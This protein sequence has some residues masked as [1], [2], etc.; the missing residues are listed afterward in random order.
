METEVRN[1]LV[2]R[3]M[4]V[5]MIAVLAAG[6]ASCGKEGNRKDG[7]ADELHAEGGA[8]E[9]PILDGLD[10]D[11]NNQRRLFFASTA[12]DAPGLYAVNPRF[13]E[14]GAELVDDQI[15]PGAF[16]YYSVH[17]G[18]VNESTKALDG[19]Y[20]HQL[21]YSVK[22]P[23]EDAGPGITGYLHGQLRRV[24]TDSEQ[25]SVLP[26]QVG[27][28]DLGGRVFVET[29]RKMF[30]DFQEPLRTSF[31][32]KGPG[33]DS[34]ARVRLADAASVEPTI[35]GKNIGLVT[36]VAKPDAEPGTDWLVVHEKDEGKL[37][38]V[39]D[40][41]A[42]VAPVRFK[43]SGEEVKGVSNAEKLHELVSGE[44]M[45][46][47]S[48]EERALG[49]VW[50]YETDDS[51]G[52][53]GTIRALLNADGEKLVINLT[54]FTNDLGPPPEELTA[55]HQGAFFFASSHGG[56]GWSKLYRLDA[57]GWSR[58][59]HSAPAGSAKKDGQA[60]YFYSE[61]APFLLDAGSDGLL[62]SLGARLER[63]RANDADVNKWTRE[64]LTDQH[65]EDPYQSKL[66]K[67]HDTTVYAV[68]DG[69]VFYNAQHYYNRKYIHVAVALNVRDKQRVVLKN[70]TWI[71]AST[72][73][74]GTVNNRR[75]E[76]ELSEVFAL[77]NGREVAAVSAAD[78][79][80]G[81]VILGQLPASTKNVTMY[82]LGPG[83]HRLLRVE[84][85]KN[86]HE[87]VYVNTR[88]S[89]SLV[90]LMDS[91]ARDWE[92]PIGKPAA[93]GN[94]LKLPIQAKNT[95]PL[96]FF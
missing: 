12:Q 58:F 92:M 78:P 55:E 42:P 75:T 83:P 6:V 90:H 4:T 46:V 40:E 3:V 96:T 50:V 8:I 49:E 60:S 5:L 84:H 36:A 22:A 86:A 35:V 71:G 76:L 16:H 14:R 2:R 38:R 94:Q 93:S 44:V 26:V 37:A 43:D 31:L 17:A 54:P 53:G 9:L 89:D 85:E 95:R 63:V 34:W 15:E 13:P 24:S 45:L 65:D 1:V 11:A 57:K 21:L 79:M 69:W 67:N 59:V 70:A 10:G 33:S 28:S 81:A 88:E 80:R 77:R 62:W 51:T 48:F 47:I 39:D 27:S 91:L 82:G 66:E 73:G 74:K 18:E 61:L 41:F 20:I 56:D 25:D 68:R 19:F 64:F 7:D 32:Y 52:A 23:D 30:F 29:P 87:V 72:S